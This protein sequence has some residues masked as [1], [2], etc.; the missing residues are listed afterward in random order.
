MAAADE[1]F[2]QAVAAPK[3]LWSRLRRGAAL[4][5]RARAG[6]GAPARGAGAA[7]TG[8]SA[9]LFEYTE[10]RVYEALEQRWRDRRVGPISEYRPDVRYN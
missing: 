6:I 2:T 3:A 4:V 5:A 1:E 8:R 10:R 9:R 7:V